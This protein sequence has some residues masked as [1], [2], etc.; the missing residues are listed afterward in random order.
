MHIYVYM[1]INTYT[2]IHLCTYFLKMH[3]S[4]GPSN[5]RRLGSAPECFFAMNVFANVDMQGRF[6]RKDA[7]TLCDGVILLNA[8]HVCACVRVCVCEREK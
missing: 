2:Y 5:E 3:L 8:L 1:C 6:R 4:A 7:L